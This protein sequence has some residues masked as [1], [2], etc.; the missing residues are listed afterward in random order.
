MNDQNRGASADLTTY[1]S[2]TLN[3]YF[4]SQRAKIDGRLAQRLVS[5]IEEATSSL[6]VAI[7][8]LTEPSV[9]A[10]L[11]A[12]SRKRGV[13]LRIAFDA[14]G[15]RPTNTIADPKP[16]KTQRA[17]AKAGLTKFAKGVHETGRHL[18]HDK[19]VIRDG[20]A[21][22]TGSANFT[23]GGLVLQDNTCIEA[24]SAAL[25][26][27]YQPVFDDL[28]SRPAALAAPTLQRP[29]KL[30][31]ASVSVYFA[32][33][34]GEGVDDLCVRLLGEARKVRLMAFVL[35][36]PDILRAL[37]GF[38]GAR[39]NIRGI[40]DPAALATARKIKTLDPQMLWW[41]SD[42]RIRVARSHKFSPTRDND[43]QH[44]KVLILDDRRVICG[45]YNLSEN[46]EANDENLLLIESRKVAAA[47]SAY[48]DAV[49]A[50]GRVRRG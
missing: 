20:K 19:F 41:T 40:V 36:D 10:A 28:W 2:R 46:A 30:G 34:A 3:V 26:K 18:M 21:V 31:E 22:W 12:V 39:A 8:D 38:K 43:F 33:A 5:F 4:N 9:L 50:T 42:A 17:I 24:R 47:Y 27:L 14:S 35:T 29:V 45:S 25:A 1:T 11:R 49:Y 13:R 37:A 16:G 6:D 7:Y 32:P 15:E 48:F 23:K 44:N